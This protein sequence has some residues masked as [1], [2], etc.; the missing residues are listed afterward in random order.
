MVHAGVGVSTQRDTQR[1]A[2]EATRAALTQAGSPGADFALVFATTAHGAS[3]SL[4]LRTVKEVAQ[5][6]DVVGCSAGGVLTLA[7]E[8][9]RAPAVAVLVVRADTLTS[10]RFFVPQLRGRAYEVGEEV[11]KA[12]RPSLGADNLLVVFPDSYNFHPVLFFA[13]LA[14]A[15]PHLPVVGGGASEDG[16]IG[17]TFQ[18]CGDT[19]SNDAVSGILLSGHFS[20]T[21]AVSQSC[22]PISPVYT[23]TKAQ[24]NVIYELDGRSAFTVFAEVVRPP[25]LED[26]RRA[27][28]CVFVGLPVDPAAQRLAPGEYVV[29]HI[30]GFDPHQGGIAVAD[31]VRPGQ[32]LLF[33][34]RDATGAREDLKR[35]LAA[36]GEHWQGRSPAFGL[37]FN[38]IGRGS[39]LYGFPDLD[40][41]YIK[42]YLG[43]FPLIGFFTG[44]EIAPLQH[45][46]ALHQYSGV[47]TLIGE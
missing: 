15:V 24:R 26:L 40:T 23:V 29:R 18:F 14:R 31:E 44:C 10:R 38:C 16:T 21:I 41:S 36:E 35:V 47:L 28:A 3:Y 19:V 11:G 6:R 5:A 1:A 8:V 42:Q 37:Y 30:I 7:G 13:G 33:T 25:L 12:V 20:Y 34:L 39:G 46:A 27:A 4:L 2:L 45:R 32:R 22:Q 43:E 17:E 9:E